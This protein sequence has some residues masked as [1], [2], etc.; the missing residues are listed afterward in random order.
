MDRLGCL[1]CGMHCAPGNERDGD[2]DMRV[3]VF[4]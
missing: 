2:T 3:P 4:C 1:L